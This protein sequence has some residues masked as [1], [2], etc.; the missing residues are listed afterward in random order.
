MRR[1]FI[2]SSIWAGSLLIA[3]AIVESYF[4]RK[5]EFMG[6]TV[7]I[8]SSTSRIAI[9]KQIAQ[10]YGPMIL[11]I[12]SA[13]F[14]KLL[15]TIPDSKVE[16]YRFR[17]ATAA[18]ILFNAIVLG[19]LSSYHFE[20]GEGEVINIVTTAKEIAVVL[21]FLVAWPNVH[22]FGARPPSDTA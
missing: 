11:M 7:H 8:L 1:R 16:I 12:G 9:Y 14:S 17:L 20:V 4:F 13:W 10:I 19:L 5:V 6:Q 3:I 21:M 18:T 15:K 22:Y 2:L